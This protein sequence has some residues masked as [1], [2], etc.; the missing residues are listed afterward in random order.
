MDP[1]FRP[2]TINKTEIKNR[3]YMVTM[4]L[5]MVLDYEVSDQLCAFYAERAKG[6]TGAVC[7]GF[8]SVD[9]VGSAP[10]NIGGHDDKY[11][12]GLAK[13]AAAINDN[14]AVSIAQINHTGPYAHAMALPK[15]ASPIGPSAVKSGFTGLMPKVLEHD[16]I[17]ETINSYA[18]AA[19]RVKEAG[20]S[21]VEILMGTGYLV[22]S[23]LSPITNLRDDEWGGTAE[24]RMKYGVEVVKATRKLV[25]PDYPIVIRMNGNDMVEGGMR[26]DDL[27][28]FAVALEAASA[29]AFCINVG[30]HEARV[31]QITMGVPR[32]NFAYLARGMKEV[33]KTPVIASHRINDVDDMRIM[34]EDGYCDMVGVGRG[35]IAEPDLAKKAQEGREDEIL[36]CIGCGQGCFDHVFL[37][38]PVECLVNPKAGH[39]TDPAIVKADKAKKVAIVGGG[40]AG[41][42]AALAAKERGHDVTIYEKQEYLGGQLWLAGAPP[43]REEFLTMIDDYEAQLIAAGVRIEVN[44]EVTTALLKEKKFDTVI[45][46]TGAKPILP[47]IKGVDGPNVIQAWDF[48]AGYVHTGQQVVV[49]GGGAVGVE[50]AHTLAEEGTLPAETLKFLLIHKAENYD[51]LRHLATHGNKKVTMVEMLPRVGKDIG[52]STRWTMMAD[53]ERFG[54]EVVTKT[55]VL[56]INSEGVMVEDASGIRTIPADT[57]VMAVGS[58]PYNP[59]ESELVDS[60]ME[61]I[62]IGDAKKIALAFD[63][64]HA[65]YKAG[66]SI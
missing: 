34:L 39:E 12:P 10:I 54:V 59:L 47:P 25:G 43:G 58:K 55:K 7:I 51:E 26:G 65:G 31:P 24:K 14:G 4:H 46:A 53:L 11:I 57:V 1:L 15:G 37:L 9:R 6:G 28:N 42:N 23:F 44:T 19:R 60:G 48:L 8:L 56:E 62:T 27:R 38:R 5:N 64:T 16:E 61:V 21:M 3:L 22:S 17:L 20:F 35:L 63:A 45:L 32:C 50:T 30:W 18:Q 66:K 36:H 33:L 13:L 52:K 29:D 40:P 2:I 41:I 49:V